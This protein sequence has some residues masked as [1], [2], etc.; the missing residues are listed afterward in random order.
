M[1]QQG[2]HFRHLWGCWL[3]LAVHICKV[4]QPECSRLA[5]QSPFCLSSNL[6]GSLDQHCSSPSF[7]WS[8]HN[9]MDAR[10]HLQDD[11]QATNDP[12]GSPCAWCILLTPLGL[13]PHESWF[14]VVP[15]HSLALLDWF[16]YLRWYLDAV[17]VKY[18]KGTY[19]VTIVTLVPWDIGTSTASLAVL[20]AANPVL[21]S[22]KS[23][24][25]WQ[26]ADYIARRLSHFGGLWRA[27]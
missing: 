15:R 20:W 23:E 12:Q 18:R 17:R 7:A 9:Y 24:M 1:V 27:A 11:T 4:L 13:I 6:S 10:Y 25:R 22:M 14:R 2:V 8:V 3:V 26:V 19:S 21:P 5:G 16:P